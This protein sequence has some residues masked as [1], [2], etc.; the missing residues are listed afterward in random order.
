MPCASMPPEPLKRNIFV[1]YVGLR[2][3][4][5]RGIRRITLVLHWYGLLN[6]RRYRS[7]WAWGGRIKRLRLSSVTV[8]STIVVLPTVTVTALTIVIGLLRLLTL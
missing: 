6:W 1:V 3:P 4:L 8:L 7:G 2:W 5:L